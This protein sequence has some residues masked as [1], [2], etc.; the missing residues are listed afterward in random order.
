MSHVGIVAMSEPA[1]GGTFQYTLSMIDA[2]RRIKKNKYTIFT[3]ATNHSYD[4]LGLP[5]VRLPA[6]GRT[7][8]EILRTRL[9]PD[10]G[11]GL[12]SG[13]EKLIAPIYSTRLLA[14]RQPFLFTLHDLQEKYYPQNFTIAQRIWRNFINKSLSRAADGIICESHQVKSDIQRFLAVDQSKITVIAAPPA[15]DFSA[16]HVNSAEFKE[17][18]K[19]VVLP[20]QFLFYPA[21]FF[22]HKNH[23]RLVEAL[24]VI[25]RSFPDCHLLLTGQ[26]K[27]DFGKVIR[28]VAE[29]GIQNR[30]THLGYV[31]TDMLAAVYLRATVV[32][33]PTLFESI[34]IPVYEAFRLGV[35]VCA[36]NVVAL[37]EQI[38]NAG[39]LFD[40]LS[41]EDM[42]E[43][44]SS[45]LGNPELQTELI[46]RGKAR[47][48]GLTPNR[49]AAQLEVVV[50]HL[51]QAHPRS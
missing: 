37:P 11:G 22:P 6:A 21:Q 17:A 20:R 28:R 19:K 4:E 5:I 35:P 45:V 2:L 14:S 47:V 23:I 36:S 24:A 18:A 9:L 27:Y 8:V 29:L 39:V 30:V 26:S 16:E 44:I 34:S 42:A 38:G 43:K 49:Y 41:I 25:L 12:F 1:L 15:T 31:D 48:G 10:N 46:R 3:S 32:V 7:I 13:V 40:P 50:D 33:V 51:G